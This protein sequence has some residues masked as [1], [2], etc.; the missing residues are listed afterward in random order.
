MTN[1]FE[2]NNSLLKKT[3]T[4]IPGS[5]KDSAIDLIDQ[6]NKTES[7]S[8]NESTIDWKVIADIID[9]VSDLPDPG[10]LPIPQ[11]PQID[12]ALL[13]KLLELGESEQDDSSGVD[14]G[15]IVDKLPPLTIPD[16]TDLI[17]PTTLP[18]IDPAVLERLLELGQAADNES[19]DGESQGPVALTPEIMDVLN[20]IPQNIIKDLV[21]QLQDALKEGLT[22]PEVDLGIITEIV[23]EG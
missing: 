18:D 22:R 2:L 11:F 8:S 4:Q 13:E 5:I 3:V 16:V 10:F 7:E 14:W 17:P 19:D 9:S 15:N 12:P 20:K 21:E 6:V 23:P 1:S